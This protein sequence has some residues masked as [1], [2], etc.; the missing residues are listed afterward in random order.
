MEIIDYS[1][2]GEDWF[3]IPVE[4]AE[5]NEKKNNPY[6]ITKNP[7]NEIESK[8][9]NFL[10]QKREFPKTEKDKINQVNKLINDLGLNQKFLLIDRKNIQNTKKNN[11]SSEGLNENFSNTKN[12]IDDINKSNTFSQNS[13]FNHTFIE[14]ARQIINLSNNFTNKKIIDIP[15]EEIEAYFKQDTKQDNNNSSNT[16]SQSINNDNN[17]IYNSN[18]SINNT[19]NNDNFIN[20]NINTNFQNEKNNNANNKKNINNSIIN[21]IN[22]KKENEKPNNNNH[23]RNHNNDNNHNKNNNINKNNFNNKNNKNNYNINYHSKRYKGACD[24]NSNDGTIKFNG[25]YQRNIY[26]GEVEFRPDTHYIFLITANDFN[27]ENKECDYSWKVKIKCNPQFLGVGLADKNKVRENNYKF[28]GDKKFYNGV[29]CLY[30]MY[31]TDLKT[32]QVHPWSAVNNDLNNYVVNFPVFKENLEITMIYKCNENILIFSAKNN[33]KIYKME[34]VKAVGSEGNTTLTPCII[35]Y[36]KGDAVQ[37]SDLFP[38]NN[39]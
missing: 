14:K 1:E 21:N 29:F 31:K 30:T 37:V 15:K 12:Y 32:Y 39:N 20:I 22:N 10:N 38:I 5:K 11:F 35:F 2:Y 17:T 13:S 4:N 19:I 24:Y 33:K 6:K 34:K 36:T 16:T 3:G 26:T 18:N 23:N 25:R 8:E 9:K 27:C 7:T 28:Y